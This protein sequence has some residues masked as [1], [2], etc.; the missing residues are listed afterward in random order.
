MIRLLIIL[1]VLPL[2][3]QAQSKL[4]INGDQERYERDRREHELCMRDPACVHWRNQQHE[5]M[6]SGLPRSRIENEL[7]QLRWEVE[8]LRS[9]IAK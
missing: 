2:P 7:D 5:Q 4:D 8:V 6:R 9:Q 3:V 1:M